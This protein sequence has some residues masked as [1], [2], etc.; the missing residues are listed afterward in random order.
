LHRQAHLDLA[1]IPDADPERRA[2]PPHHRRI[3][4]AV[5]LRQYDLMPFA[6]PAALA[7]AQA[8][9]DFEALRFAG[10]RV[11][12]TGRAALVTAGSMPEPAWRSGR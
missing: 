3:L 5:R 2:V 12:V 10:V 7:R 8:T 1:G 4:G 9:M 6:C 11:D